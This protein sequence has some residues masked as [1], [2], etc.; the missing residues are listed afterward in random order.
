MN[1]LIYQR[2]EITDLLKG[3]ERNFWT[4]CT[5]RKLPPDKKKKRK[6]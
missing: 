4:K 6:K 1:S 5:R 3:I 2:N